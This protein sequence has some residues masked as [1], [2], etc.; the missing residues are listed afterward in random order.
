MS[1]QT[2]QQLKVL[3]F[4]SAVLMPM[5]LVVGLFGT[6]FKLAEYDAPEPFYLMLAGMGAL[7]VGMLL[8]FHYRRW[9]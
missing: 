1:Y 7:A 2:N 9:L 6:N 3:T 5:T 8:Y 4:L